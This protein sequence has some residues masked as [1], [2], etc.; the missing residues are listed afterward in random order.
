MTNQENIYLTVSVFL[1][2]TLHVTCRPFEHAFTYPVYHYWFIFDTNQAIPYDDIVVQ[3]S[4]YQ[5]TV[6]RKLSL[7]L[8]SYSSSF[9]QTRTASLE[10][11]SI[12]IRE[13]GVAV[14]TNNREY[15]PLDFNDKSR[16]QYKLDFN[17]LLHSCSLN[18]INVVRP[19]CINDVRDY[20]TSQ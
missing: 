1:F 6:S 16:S 3:D 9:W 13:G 5:G 11:F 4:F 15:P 20:F 2:K 7:A 17:L 12:Q 14:E 8:T 19:R 18:R 10:H